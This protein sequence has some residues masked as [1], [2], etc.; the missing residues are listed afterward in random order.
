MPS[1]RS[2]PLSNAENARAIS[3]GLT[4]SAPRPIAKYFFSG[5]VIPSCFAVRTIAPGPTSWVS[6]A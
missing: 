4:A 5:L 2:P 1:I 6:C 3:S